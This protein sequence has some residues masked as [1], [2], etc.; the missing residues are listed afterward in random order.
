MLPLLQAVGSGRELCM[1]ELVEFLAQVFKLGEKDRKQMLPRGKQRTFDSRVGWARTYLKKAGLLET[2]R[3]GRVRITSRGI[4]VLKTNLPKID[5]KF[6]M[7]FTEFAVASKRIENA[8]LNQADFEPLVL[9]MLV[10]KKYPVKTWAIEKQL[11]TELK[12]S[13]ADLM[14]GKGNV[15]HWKKT[16]QYALYHY[17][18]DSQLI[19]LVGKGQ[20]MITEKGLEKAPKDSQVQQRVRKV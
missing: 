11:E 6:L 8:Q 13:K 2:P 16:L 18:Q 1:N 12:F 15:V 19:R 14:V 7:Q 4:D 3:V 20:W 17:M 5:R 9:K 10:G